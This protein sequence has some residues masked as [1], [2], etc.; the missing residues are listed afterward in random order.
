MGSEF[1]R[2]SFVLGAGGGAVAAGLAIPSVARA[3]TVLR[4][5]TIDPP[6][7]VGP[8]LVLPR[9]AKAVEE[10]SGGA[11]RVE[12]YNAGELIPTPE[13][14][15][16][17]AAGV[18]DLSYTA[19]VYYTGALA[20]NALSYTS[21]PP[22]MIPTANDGAE[23]YLHK[24]VD[25][26]IAKAYRPEG[27]EFLGSVSL[28]DPITFWSKQRIESVSDLAGFKVRSF[29]FAAKTLG[30]L[31][32]S[33]VFMPH[34]EVYTALSQGT[35]DGSMT[36]AS[37]YKRAKY[38]EVAPFIY[39]PG[40]YNWTH[41][42]FMVSGGTWEKLTE[43][44]R[45]IIHYA[46]RNLSTEMQHFTWLEYRQMLLELADMGS[47]LVT[48]SEEDAAAVL[49]AGQ[50]FIPEIRQLSAE[51]DRGMTIIDDHVKSLYGSI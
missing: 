17:L 27:V 16:G 43:E 38:F 31:G 23:I 28:G 24:G 3:Q 49:E 34:Q 33:P 47:T 30:K 25:E 8:S 41:M 15:A 26:I 32:A 46:V 14:P 6:S 11:L 12:I 40:W 35:I 19:N 42:C 39:Q 51:V 5:Q 9:F 50:S 21:L 37:Y 29:G 22:M 48:W 7:F 2:R 18:I 20:E 45:K 44:Q 1:S 13:I 36:N 4:L 10:M